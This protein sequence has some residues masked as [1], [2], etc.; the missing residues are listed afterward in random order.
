MEGGRFDTNSQNGDNPPPQDGACPPGVRPPVAGART[1]WVFYDNSSHDNNDPDVPTYGSAAAGPVGT[2]MSLS[3]AR[4]DTV[5]DNV[6]ANN[7]AW[8]DVLVP[9]PDSGPPCTGGTQLGVACLFD[10]SGDAV[11]GNRY[12]HNGSFGNPTNGDIGATNLELGPTDC[13]RANTDA[14]GDLT[15]S[16]PD[17]ESLYPECTGLTVLP[18]ANALFTD[19]VACD[20]NSISIGPVEGD[21]VCLPGTHYPRQTEVVMHPLPGASSLTAPS[22]T[23][24]STMPDPCRGDPDIAGSSLPASPW[25]P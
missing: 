13:F 11:I 14:D 15:T 3:G 6:F 1:C 10:E 24:L 18:D 7:D 20:S 4:D 8:G 23:N 19:E 17:A 5:M 12:V 9:F 2:G 22:S 16:P 25:C 21:A